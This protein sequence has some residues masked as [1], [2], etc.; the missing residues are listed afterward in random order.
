MSSSLCGSAWGTGSSAGVGVGAAVRVS[1]SAFAAA[2]CWKASHRLLTVVMSGLPVDAGTDSTTTGRRSRGV[3]TSETEEEAM[4][5]LKIG[6]LVVWVLCVRLISTE[7]DGYFERQW[8]H[9]RP[10]LP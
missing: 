9:S 1:A 4:S 7:R 3:I 8:S 6:T 10:I 2:V 5:G